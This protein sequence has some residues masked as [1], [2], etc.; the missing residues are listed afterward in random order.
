MAADLITNLIINNKEFNKN[1]AQSKAQVEAFKNIQGAVV[2]AVGK[3]AGAIGIAAGG[4]EAMNKLIHSSQGLQDTFEWNLSACKDGVDMFFHSLA[5]GDFT[6]FNQGIESTYNNLIRLQQLRDDFADAKVSNNIYRAQYQFQSQ[7]LKAIISDNTSTKE[8]KKKAADDLKKITE[9]YSKQLTSTNDINV[10]QMMQNAQTKTGRYFGKED[11]IRFFKVYNNPASFDER[12]GKF[13]DYTSTMNALKKKEF[14]YETKQSGMGA[15]A[16]IITVKTADPKVQ[17]QMKQLQKENNEL[18][19]MYILAQHNDKTWE[20]LS[21]SVIEYYSAQGEAAQ[22]LN[23]LIKQQNK[24]DKEPKGGSNKDNK[25]KIEV[26]PEKGSL[27]LLNNQ[28]SELKKQYL[29][30]NTDDARKELFK[31]ITEVE[32]EQ[33]NLNIKARYNE[34]KAPLKKAGIDT[35]GLNTKDIKINPITKKDVKNTN[36]YAESLN[37]ISTLM[38]SI[39]NLTNEG[40]AA[41][42]TW[43]ATLLTSIATVIPAIQALTTVKKGE[44]VVNGIKSA[45]ETPVVGWLLAAAGAAAVIASFASIPKAAEG[46]VAYGNTLVN[47]GEYAGASSNPE[48]IAPLNKLKALLHTENNNKESSLGGEVVFRIAG[49]ELHGVLNNYSRKQSK[50]K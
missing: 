10:S 50:I 29:S 2:S 16:M 26:V 6:A 11:V 25:E 45:S 46:G 17:A 14:K 44:A 33:I 37:S 36:D 35:K 48:V 1:L 13:D 9:Q 18:D 38:G 5:S 42:L 43:G 4:L 19:R 34:E 21:T 47:V 23:F 27:D 30:V 8:Q 15:N 41:W 31:L 32:K 49:N 24:T 39:T 22:N 20:E 12:K 7:E 3:F 28:L 40:T